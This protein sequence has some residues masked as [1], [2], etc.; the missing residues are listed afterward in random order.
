MP[1]DSGRD[2]HAPGEY[3]GQDEHEQKDAQC[4]RWPKPLVVLYKPEHAAEDE[5]G[6]DCGRPHR[7]PLAVGCTLRCQAP[8]VKE[9]EPASVEGEEV[10][11]A[12][13]MPEPAE[14]PEAAAR[15]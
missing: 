7:I 15:Q 5:H 10:L 1:G 8:I 12:L 9:P 6:G 14:L 13:K 4:G 3:A 11:L 2:Q